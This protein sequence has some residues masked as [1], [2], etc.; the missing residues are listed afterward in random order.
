MSEIV[1]LNQLIVRF[2][3]VDVELMNRR[4]VFMR[5]RVFCG[6]YGYRKS[7]AEYQKYKNMGGMDCLYCCFML[8]LL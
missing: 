7:R 8:E 3:T 4:T 5:Q 1:K 6:K 2:R